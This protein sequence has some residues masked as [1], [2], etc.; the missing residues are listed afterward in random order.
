MPWS[1][2]SG[3][4]SWTPNWDI[5]SEGGALFG[6]KD[7]DRALRQG[8]TRAQISSYMSANPDVVHATNRAENVGTTVDNQE[9]QNLFQQVTDTSTSGPSNQWGGEFYGEADRA[10]DTDTSLGDA[11]AT[12]IQIRDYIGGDTASHFNEA[13][14]YGGNESYQGTIDKVVSEA[15]TET[16]TNTNVAQQQTITDQGDKIG[17]LEDD[18]TTLSG[19]YTT[20]QGK[21]DALTDKY[22]GLQTDVAQAAK[23]AMKIKYTG[24]TQ[25]R[26]P[27]AMGIQAAQGTPF[28]GSGLAGTAA[29]A[30][31]NKGLKIKT[32]NV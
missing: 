8:A 4:S 30:R 14:Y 6:K 13:A 32:L 21:Y 12:N 7:V 29:L 5:A 19:N 1:P 9:H 17:D 31:P 26:N 25:V 2:S 27:S 24:S 16:N 10:F 20:L 18:Y 28:R 11:R 23:D 15:N 3:T 22:T